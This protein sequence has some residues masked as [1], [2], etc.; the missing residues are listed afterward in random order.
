MGGPGHQ[1][2]CRPYSYCMASYAFGWAVKGFVDSKPYVPASL[3]IQPYRSEPDTRSGQKPEA[4][5]GE[6]TVTELTSGASYNIY[7]WDSVEDAFTYTD[8]YKKTSFVATKDNFVYTDGTTFQSDSTTY[9]RCVQ[10]APNESET[11]VV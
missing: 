9:Y 4:L 3:A 10:E 5:K 7:R 1:A 2:N 11:A 8:K 6:L